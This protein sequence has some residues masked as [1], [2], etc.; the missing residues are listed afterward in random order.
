V[1]IGL[2]PEPDRGYV[3]RIDRRLNPTELGFIGND[4]V[5]KHFPDVVNVGFTAQM[6][7]RLD[8]IEEGTADWLEAMNQFYGA[9]SKWLE[10]AKKKMKNVKAMEEPTDQVCEK[11]GQTMVIKWGR[12][13]KFLAC[14]GY[15][16]CKTTK[17]IGK[18]ERKPDVL[19][20]A[21]KES[22]V[23]SFL[24]VF[25]GPVKAEEIDS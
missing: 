16:D 11:C 17:R 10:H 20:R 24:E 22:A 14:S 18:E 2:P 3:E 5:V 25:P 21:K 1:V 15:P 19:E 7:T 23:Q 9:F 13:G 12:F 4:L 8:E 6:E